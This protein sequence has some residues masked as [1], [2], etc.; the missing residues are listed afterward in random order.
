MA[1]HILVGYLGPGDIFQ[2]FVGAKELAAGRSMNPTANMRERVA[3]WLD[4][5]PL[6][7]AGLPD[8]PALGSLRASSLDSGAR[9]LVVQA[10]P[11]FH[12]FLLAPLVKLCRSIQ[13][14]YL[15]VTLVNIAAYVLLLLLLWRSTNLPAVVPA[16]AVALLCLLALDW[17]PF[18]AN[19]RQGQ[20]GVVVAL[21]VIGGWHCLSHDRPWPAGILIGLAAL[22]K[23]FPALLI[24]W[25]LLRNRRAFVAALGTVSVAV[26]L[27][28]LT[29]GPGAFID[30]FHAAQAVEANFGRARNNS[31]LSSIISY[32]TG[33]PAAIFGD[34][35]L[36]GYAVFLM[37]RKR[38]PVLE[39]S[40][41]VVLS[42]LL[43]P[44]SE[45]FYFPI[46]LLPLATVA[47]EIRP[48]AMLAIL[49]CFSFPDQVVWRSTELL[50]PVLGDRLAW[51]L[52][53]FPTF[54]ML[55]LWYWTARREPSSHESGP[56]IASLS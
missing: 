30:Y 29:R 42:C 47:S 53:S 7:S 11:P 48:T 5:E 32:V 44:T 15:A 25:L 33:S 28:Y 51:L 55:A 49:I 21:L 10:H 22:I 18:L 12:I 19:L 46:L 38:T 20:I 4:R 50:T 8:W 3:Y 54:A 31:S 45:A 16:G 56:S 39:F 14:T 2:D 43:S 37:L 27:L 1:S 41:F 34:A 35:L 9:Q 36:F 23:M 52:C 26:L 24:V 17:Q 40:S 13:R 6:D